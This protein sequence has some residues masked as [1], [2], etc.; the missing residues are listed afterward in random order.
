MSSTP[1][2]A[3]L[4][5]L[6]VPDVAGWRAWLA[7]HHGDSPGV[8]L[9]LA[10]KGTVEPT[11]LSYDEALPEALCQGWID[12]QVQRRDAGTFRQRWTPRRPRSRWSARNVALA[13]GLIE[14][15]RMCP[16]GLAEIERAKADGRWDAA[17]AGP[18]TARVP[19]DLT[20]ALAGQPRAAAMFEILTAQ[21]RYAILHRVEAVKR[22]ETRARR[23]ADFVAML[24]RGETVYPQRRRLPDN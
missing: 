11:S 13:T 21:N 8:W 5:E 3:D 17:Y 2:G 10:R 1:T 12:G 6:V 18:A 7:G 22:P 9:V 14:A 19:D 15:G 16:A 24:A 4:A 23:I 20:A